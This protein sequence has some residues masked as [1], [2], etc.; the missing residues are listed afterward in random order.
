[1][2]DPSEFPII[3]VIRSIRGLS[4]FQFEQLLFRSVAGRYEPIVTSRLL[5]GGEKLLAVSGQP[6]NGLLIWQK[7]DC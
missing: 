6:E 7:A 4:C 1:M 2:G 5:Q 3:R